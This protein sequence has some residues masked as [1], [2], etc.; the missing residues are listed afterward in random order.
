MPALMGLHGTKFLKFKIVRL[1]A[2]GLLGLFAWR[3]WQKEHEVVTK[4]EPWYCFGSGLLREV[5]EAIGRVLPAGLM[6]VP[7]DFGDLPPLDGDILGEWHAIMYSI[8][9]LLLP[10]C[11]KR[12]GWIVWLIRVASSGPWWSCI[13]MDFPKEFLLEEA[14]GLLDS[15]QAG[16]L[17]GGPGPQGLTWTAPDQAQQEQQGTGIFLSIPL[18][19]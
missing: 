19:L 10:P 5:E 18:A 7:S 6:S 2:D 9:S 11:H 12:L 3:C 13:G 8:L 16:L 17:L 4:S 14:S 1:S 15:D